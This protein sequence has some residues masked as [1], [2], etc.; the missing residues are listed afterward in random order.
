MLGQPFATILARTDPFDL[1]Q[2]LERY[3]RSLSGE[4]IRFTL[5]A[6]LPVMNQ[7][8]RDEFAPLLDDPDDERLKHSFAHALKSNLRAIPLFGPGFCQGVIAH[9]PGD[10]TVALGEEGH[11][12]PQLRPFAIA[13]VALALVIIGAAAEHAWNTARATAQ[14]PAVLMTPLPLAA[15]DAV[16]AATAVPR[17]VHSAPPAVRHTTAPAT[18]PPATP[19]QVNAAPAIAAPQPAPVTPKRIA[20]RRTAPPGRGESTV[21][22]ARSTPG[23]SPEPST[24]DVSDMPQAYTDATPLPKYETPP[25]ARVPANVHVATPTPGPNRFFL[26]QTIRGTLKTLDRLNPFKHHSEPEPTPSPS[27]GPRP[28]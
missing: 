20:A 12:L 28:L 15:Q 16:P 9:V 7:A 6:A 25:A 18:P 26:H 11:R 24:V 8:Y 10:R 2:A 21:V 13:I 1:A 17:P 27:T 4:Q 5:R 14:T 3:I 19:A 23:P 22:I